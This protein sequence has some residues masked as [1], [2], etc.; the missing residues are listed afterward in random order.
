LHADSP[1]NASHED[2][3]SRRLSAPRAPIR[4]LNAER[5]SSRFAP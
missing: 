3:D 1:P 2:R 4:I 5:N